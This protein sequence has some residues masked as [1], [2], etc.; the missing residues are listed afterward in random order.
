[1]KDSHLTPCS[2]AFAGGC[3]SHLVPVSSTS[4]A[5]KEWLREA[6]VFW[7]PN[8]KPLLDQNEHGIC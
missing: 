7:Q 6:W 2:A 5:L 1:M 8:P 3:R 4:P